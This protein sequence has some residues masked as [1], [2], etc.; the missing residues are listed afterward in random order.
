MQT[1]NKQN[2]GTINVILWIKTKKDN[3]KHKNSLNSLSKLVDWPEK[4]KQT[5]WILGFEWKSMCCR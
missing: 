4:R 1:K 5:L 2:E 3:E